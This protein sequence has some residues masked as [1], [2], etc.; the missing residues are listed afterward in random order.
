MTQFVSL[1]AGF[2]ASALESYFILEEDVG[3][4]VRV[5]D[6]RRQ[7]AE[8]APVFHRRRDDGEGDEHRER[9]RSEGGRCYDANS[10]DRPDEGWK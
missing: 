7:L 8:R 5:Y 2:L 1:R 6:L 9:R 4:R 3:L 10:G